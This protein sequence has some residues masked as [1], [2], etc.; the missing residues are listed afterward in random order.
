[1]IS[2][3]IVKNPLVEKLPENT[4]DTNRWYIRSCIDKHLGNTICYTKL[5]G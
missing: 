5:K 4:I 3:C 1:M 2:P